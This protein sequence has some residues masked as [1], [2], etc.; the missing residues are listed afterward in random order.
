MTAFGHSPFGIANIPDKRASEADAK[1][2]RLYD[3]IQDLPV[4]RMRSSSTSFTIQPALPSGSSSGASNGL[5]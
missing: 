3:A 4:T 2:K 1:L 5:A